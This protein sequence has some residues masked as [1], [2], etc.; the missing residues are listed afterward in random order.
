MIQAI[1]K[2]KEKHP[3]LYE[4]ILFNIMSNVA[5]ITNFLVLALGTGFLFRSF[6]QTPFHWF[7]FDYPVKASGDGGLCGFLGFLLAYVCAQ[8]VNFIIQKKVVFGSD[9]QVTKVLPWYL[10]TVTIAG[11]ISIWLPPHVM[12]F[13]GAYVNGTIATYLANFANIVVQVLINYP[14]MKFVIMK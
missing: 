9:C 1:E 11:I 13:T 8:I 6:A 7:I 3:D 10:L 12:E 5:T 2:W 14:M 4:F